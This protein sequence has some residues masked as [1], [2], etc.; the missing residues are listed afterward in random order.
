MGRLTF[1][2]FTKKYVATLSQTGTTSIY[3][4]V[5]ETLTGNLRLREPLYL[6]AASNQLLPTLLKAS[7]HTELYDSFSVLA[8]EFTQE[9]LMVALETRS[10]ALPE[11]FHKVWA[12]YCSVVSM[13]ERNA[14]VKI[15]MADKVR[16]LL[17]ESGI[18][19]YQISKE[20]GINYANVNSWIKH[21]DA[22][23]ISIENARKV[24]QYVEANSVK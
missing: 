19:T 18:T 5:R 14:R 16:K 20:L 15:L 4:L 3:K 24:L 6:Y 17:Q 11:R 22:K 9:E 10:P 8:E 21:S 7:R 23:K 2:G 12:S 1:P 13:P